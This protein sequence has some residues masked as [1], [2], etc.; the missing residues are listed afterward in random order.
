MHA[1]T[2]DGSRTRLLRPRGV[3]VC[4]YPFEAD[5][6]LILGPLEVVSANGTLSIGGQKERAALAVLALRVG[7]T[8]SS[9]QL[10]DALWGD[11]PPR[12]SAKAVQNVIL[13]LRKVLGPALIETRRD[14]Y[15]LRVPP[16]AV[17][18]HRFNRLVD[19]ARRDVVRGDVVNAAAT[20]AAALVLWRGRP[21]PELADWST[22]QI[23]VARLEEMQRSA[24]EELAD[25]ELA[26]GHHSEWIVRL[27]AMVAAAPLRE[28]RWAQLMLALARSGRQGDALPRVYQRARE[29]LG[30]ELG[31][32]PSKALARLEEAILS[33]TPEVDWHPSLVASGTALSTLP[34]G[35]VTFLLSDIVGSTALWECDAQSMANAV[36]RHDTLIHG[37]VDANGGTV[38]KA[39]G[40]GDSTFSVFSRATDALGA[41]LSAQRALVREA[42]P[43]STPLTARMALHTGEAFER[44]GDYYGPTVNRAA[45]IRHLAGGG[46]VLVSQS[47]AELVRD[48]LPD[49]TTLIELG[50]HVLSDLVRAE[51]ILGLAAPGLPEPSTAQAATL[52]SSSDGTLPMP[53][54]LRDAAEELFVGRAPELEALER[55][56]K[57]A[58]IGEPRAVF[59]SGE[60]GVGKT[61]LVAQLARAVVAE[62]GAV[63]YGRCDE[64]LGIPY[65]PWVEALD[66][67]IRHEPRELLASQ[68]GAHRGQ[69]SRLMP[70]LAERFGDRS[71]VQMG[72]PGDE[73]HLLFR[74]VV[75][76]ITRV[77]SDTPH[78][79]VLEDLHWA[80]KPSLLV[81]R[82]LLASTDRRRLLVVGTYR[83]SDLAA[84]HPL[85]DALAAL[86]REP[87]VPRL[88]LRGLSE[89]EVVALLETA[90]GHEMDEVGL[91]LAHAVYRETDGNPFFASEILRHLVETEV[92][93]QRGDGR[94]IAEVDFRD[95]GRLPTGV[96]EVIEH[97][98]ARLGDEVEQTLRTAAVI[99]RDFD[100]GLLANVTDRSEDQTL[101]L[102]EAAI[103]AMVIREVPQRPGRLTFSHA[104]IEHALYDDLGLTRRQRLHRRIA[105]A[106]EAL[107]GDDPGDRLAE[108][109]HHWAQAGQPADADKAADYARRAG[110]FALGKLAPDDA[111]AWYRQAL[112]LIGAQP[113]PD[114]H[115]RCETLVRLGTAQRQAG[116]PKSRETL[117]RAAHLAQRLGD[118]SLLI[119][120]ALAS[121]Q[122]RTSIAGAPVDEE[123]VALLEAALEMTTG[124]ETPE[125]AMLLASLAGELAWSDQREIRARALSDEALAIARRAGDDL[126]LWEVLSRRPDTISSPATLEERITNAYEQRLIADR[127]GAPNF[128]ASAAENLANAAAGRGD[129]VEVDTNLAVEIRIAAETGLAPAR[130]SAASQSAWREL[131]AGHIEE[132]EQAAEEAF[133]IASESGDPNALSFYAGQIYLIRRDQGRL[134][135]I[136][137]L[138]E[139][140]MAEN[141][142]FPAFRA[143]LAHGLCEVDRLDEARLAFEPLVT[144]RFAGFPFDLGWL[145]SMSA[146]AEVAGYLEHRSAATLLVTLLAPWRDQLAFTGITC[147]GSVARSLG[148]ALAT[149]GR[150]DEA[151]EAFEQ[152]AAVHERIEAPI[153][154]ARTRLNWASMLT[155]R[156]Q[157]GDLDRA[158]AL[159]DAALT[160]A[161]SLGLATIERQAQTL[162][163]AESET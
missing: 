100:L 125:R 84:E 68:V 42:W 110:D 156:R 103:G 120:A 93:S 124:T 72:D 157:P 21:L 62:G 141:P 94:W 104:L 82:H 38:L 39:R 58:S 55:M 60:P 161:S 52:E 127:L 109:A 91:A 119:S 67:L 54:V 73:Q 59:I 134:G 128:R 66:P 101:D 116:D 28:H 147:T 49:D 75:G 149:C 19:D 10:T 150:F 96:R 111:V 32:E 155:N 158:R 77:C 47:T 2:V 24:E 98:V 64:D 53:G 41:A 15:L 99:G 95:Q 5:E 30:T 105:T 129:L 70:D 106:L 71:A 143:A 69:L 43:E 44:E 8:V 63:L 90:A 61:S 80:D 139:Q 118:S 22:G 33:Q 11:H 135:E 18:S 65:Q 122:G 48:H 1:G 114:E 74:A 7:E 146:C 4:G 160:T 163:A 13:R 20:L 138:I 151:G 126:T 113:H 92:I 115:T 88:E 16:D 107:C 162:L 121:N 89:P 6:F 154:L 159:L 86:R 137:E 132:A 123:R 23:E 81:L 3:I 12:T 40:E 79:L 102:L 45:R 78:M 50:S 57:D 56:W 152:A 31:I 26:A 142:Q 17:D 76:F 25:I 37:A 83:P 130:W 153:E 9:D 108:L 36:A 131:L 51:R 136:I 133:R 140:T 112:E 34:S 27:E 46:Q 85:T 14:G 87:N 117:L 29:T 145:T 97:R 148:V 35:V 144:S